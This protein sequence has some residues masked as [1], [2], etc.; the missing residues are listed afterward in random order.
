MG[1]GRSEGNKIARV[2][3][4]LKLIDA[5]RGTIIWKANH[6]KVEEYWALKPSMEKMAE[7]LMSVLMKEMPH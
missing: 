6:E 3:L 7:E 1:I 5:S 2:G 4:G